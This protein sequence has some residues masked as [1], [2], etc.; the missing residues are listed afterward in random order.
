MKWTVD[1]EHTVH[2]KWCKEAPEDALDY[3]VVVLTGTEMLANIERPDLK[4]KIYGKS[5]LKA[6]VCVNELAM[7]ERE[8]GESQ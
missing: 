8:K 1:Q 4:D 6:C 7:I 5:I 2:A 3:D